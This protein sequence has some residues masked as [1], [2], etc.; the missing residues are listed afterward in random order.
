MTTSK[1]LSSQN[2]CGDTRRTVGRRPRKRVRVHA[3]RGFKS[4]RYRSATVTC[5][6]GERGPRRLAFSLGVRPPNPAR[7]GSGPPDPPSWGFGLRVR[8]GWSAFGGVLDLWLSSRVAPHCAD[9]HGPA[10]SRWL[11]TRRCPLGVAHS[12]LPTRRG[13]HS[14]LPTRRCPLGALVASPVRRRR[15]G[16]RWVRSPRRAAP[17]PPSCGGG[18]GGVGGV[19][20]LDRFLGGEFLGMHLNDL[21]RVRGL[22]F[23]LY[24]AACRAGE[25]GRRSHAM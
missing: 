25:T 7:R 13:S 15:R 16:P 1:R 18:V 14:A 10:L 3:L 22:A 23:I 21:V 6:H 5:A 17:A 8:V 9:P 19:G 20:W 4:H 12:A 24:V 11:P 2:T